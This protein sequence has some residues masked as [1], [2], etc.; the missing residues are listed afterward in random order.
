M[1][2]AAVKMIVCALNLKMKKLLMVEKYVLPR[3]GAT[4]FKHS[5][6]FFFF[7]YFFNTKPYPFIV[8]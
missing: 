1:L 8:F 4:W 2:G 3:L 6:A 7:I 5:D